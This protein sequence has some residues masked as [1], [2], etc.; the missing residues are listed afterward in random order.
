VNAR[1]HCVIANKTRGKSKLQAIADP[2]NDRAAFL[3][4][5]ETRTAFLARLRSAAETLTVI[6]R[7]KVVRLLVYTCFNGGDTMT[8]RHN[9]PI[10]SGPT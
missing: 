2:A 7:Q 3:R 8:I 9:T 4:F 10:P 6:E 1:L 5:A